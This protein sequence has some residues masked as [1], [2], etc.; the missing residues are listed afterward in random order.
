MSIKQSIM[1]QQDIHEQDETYRLCALVTV[2]QMKQCDILCVGLRQLQ[3]CRD[4]S[5]ATNEDGERE[6]RDDSQSK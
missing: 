4:L 1:A 6:V 3:A 2:P 5:S